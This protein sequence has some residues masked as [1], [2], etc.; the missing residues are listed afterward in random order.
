MAEEVGDMEGTAL[1]F[2]EGVP[3]GD[4]VGKE[5]G[6]CDVLGTLEG[7]PVGSKLT[8]GREVGEPLG[9]IDIVGVAV[10]PGVGFLVGAVGIGLF[11][12]R[13]VN[14][15]LADGGNDSVGK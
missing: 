8:E 4:S 12:G 6:D 9:S 13:G 10:G 11:V 7:A 1:G 14:V 3:E 2:D 15:G 5:L